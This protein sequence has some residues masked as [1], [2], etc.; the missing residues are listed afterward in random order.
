MHI[1]IVKPF[2]PALED[3]QQDFAACLRSGLVTNNSSHV[4]LFEEKLQQL[5]GCAI[6]PSVNCNGELA[7]YHLLQAS[8]AKLGAGDIVS[9]RLN[10]PLF[11]DAD[12]GRVAA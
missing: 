2:L 7:L 11:F 9:L 10:K 6:R 8:K 5:F 3:I 1:N 4:R 12:G